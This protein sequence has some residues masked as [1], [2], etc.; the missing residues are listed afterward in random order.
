MK[1]ALKIALLLF[2]AALVVIQFFRIDKTNPQVDEANRLEAALAVPADVSMIL[3]RS[4]ADCH[5][6]NTSYPWY[7]NIQPAAWFLKDHIDHGR[8]ELNVSEFNT[9]SPKKKKHKL[10]EIC[11]YV[12]SGEMPLPSYLWIHR[13]AALSDS[14]RN[15]LCD[16]AT[17]EAEKIAL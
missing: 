2:V 6:N 13:D 7:S 1:K 16:W 9:Y 3:S 10:E 15:A 17:A 14:E 12:R 4:C 11:K 8:R 5:S